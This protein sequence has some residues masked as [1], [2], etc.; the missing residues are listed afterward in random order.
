MK[1]CLKH[2]SQPADKDRIVTFDTE[3]FIRDIAKHEM[4]VIRDD[5]VDR[6]LRFKR[7]GT[8]SMHFD[9]LTWPGYLCYTGDMGSFLFR[10]THDMLEFFRPGP[11]DKPYRIDFRYWA[12]KVE[13]AD[14][15]DGLSNFSVEKFKAE[16]KDYFDQATDDADEWTEERKAALW[17]EIESDVLGRVDYDGDGVAWVALRE[18]EFDGF[19]FTDWERDCKEYSHRFLWCCHALEWAVNTY[20]EFHAEASR[21]KE[22]STAPRG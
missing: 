13:A 14:K 22:V 5:G 8:M 7:P 3:T 9:I 4:E 19:Q 11:N 2:E 20:D 18:F 21:E 17:K 6:H 15:G 12:E 16:V 1:I 10:R